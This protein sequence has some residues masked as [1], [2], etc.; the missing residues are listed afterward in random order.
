[1]N[2]LDLLWWVTGKELRME[3]IFVTMTSIWLLTYSCQ[4][5]ST[6]FQEIF[7]QKSQGCEPI[8]K[9]TISFRKYSLIVLLVTITYSSGQTIHLPTTVIYRDSARALLVVPTKPNLLYHKLL[10]PLASSVWKAYLKPLKPKP[11]SPINTPLLIFPSE[12]L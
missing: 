12:K 11:Q 2:E 8:N 6:L 1:M 7:A 4:H 10:P 9:F 5:L 3:I